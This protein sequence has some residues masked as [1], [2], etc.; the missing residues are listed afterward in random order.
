MSLLRREKSDP[1]KDAKEGLLATAARESEDGQEELDG[2]EE[3]VEMSATASMHPLSTASSTAA[4]DDAAADADDA[5]GAGPTRHEADAADTVSA[6]TAAE[7]AA[8]DAAG[9]SESDIDAAELDL[10][11]GHWSDCFVEDVRIASK[12]AFNPFTLFA[13]LIAGLSIFYAIV[14]HPWKYHTKARKPNLEGGFHDREAFAR[15][16]RGVGAAARNSSGRDTQQGVFAFNIAL[17]TPTTPP[18]HTH[19]TTPMTGAAHPGRV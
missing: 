1:D 16:V 19:T 18:P 17:E 14:G 2:N 12:E 7:D 5:S 3:G 10:Q 11:K 15:K 8:D 4:A 9:G 13:C 6:A